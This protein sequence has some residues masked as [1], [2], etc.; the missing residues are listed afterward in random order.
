[1]FLLANFKIISNYWK[2][3]SYLLC[4]TCEYSDNEKNVD[5]KSHVVAGT[6]A[7]PAEGTSSLIIKLLLTVFIKVH[8]L[9][10]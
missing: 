10:K 4:L 1:M 8:V 2:L 5:L 7:R 3:G 9:G 6:R